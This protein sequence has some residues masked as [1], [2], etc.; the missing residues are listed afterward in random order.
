MNMPLSGIRVLDLCIILAGPTCG[1]TLAEYGA[2]VIKIDS[3]YRPPTDRQLYDVGRGKRSICLDITNPDGLEVFYR[4]VD[5]ADV[6]LGGFR[7]GV[8]ERIGIGYEQLRERKPDIVYLAI[9]AFGQ[10]G[11]WANRP[12]YEQNAQAATGVQVRNGGRGEKPIHSPYTFNDYGT[13]LMGAYAVMLALLHRRRTGKGQF[14]HTSLAQTGSTFSSPYLIDHEGYER[15]EVEGLESRRFDALNGLYQATDGW[16]VIA[17]A[18]WKALV[19]SEAFAH[20][21]ERKEFATKELR[22]ENDSLLAEEIGA[23]FAGKK[24][25]EW[26]GLLRASG[27]SAV[28]NDDVEHILADGYPRERGLIVEEESP[29]LGKVSHAGVTPRLSETQPLLGT[30]PVF[31]EE[32]EAVLLEL[33][34]EVEEIDALRANEVIPPLE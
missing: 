8:A 14:V 4:L 16:L 32:T 29:L 21:S 27:V 20:L 25:S 6:V 18:D 30:A 1:R 15:S 9:N 7:K 26:L 10:D 28:R 5:T 33:G 22:A 24:V 17:D 19:S 13:G 3:W 34:Y 31:G 12:G 11:D 23:V 2:E